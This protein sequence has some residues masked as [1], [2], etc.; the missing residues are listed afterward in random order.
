MPPRAPLCAARDCRST[1]ALITVEGA[2]P[3]TGRERCPPAERRRR[4]GDGSR[5]GRAG[6]AGVGDSWVLHRKWSWTPPATR[7]PHRSP[8]QPGRRPVLARPAGRSPGGTPILG[9][10]A[11]AIGTG[12]S[13]RRAPT[14]GRGSR[15]PSCVGRPHASA[16]LQYDGTRPDRFPTWRAA[17]GC[18]HS[19]G[20]RVR[21]DGRVDTIPRVAA[22]HRTGVWSLVLLLLSACASGPRGDGPYGDP[23][24]RLTVQRPPA[25]RQPDPSKAPRPA[26]HSPSSWLWRLASAWTAAV[27]RAGPLPAVARHLF[28][29]FSQ[30]NKIETREPL[31]LSGATRTRTRLRARR[32]DRP[33]EVD[34]IT[35][36]LQGCLYDSTYVA[37]WT[38]SSAGE[39]ILTPSVASCTLAH[40]P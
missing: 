18:A 1:P 8:H 12:E 6:R 28:F 7:S 25:R 10:A 13:P 39:P 31:L 22:A 40:A 33:V 23:R 34:G 30:G 16:H 19:G 27:P 2:P 37:A 17:P 9:A 11:P 26:F 15:W 35:V 3:D 24:D 38:V 20:V 32:D 29:G 36:R 21:A 5:A 14:P 4:R